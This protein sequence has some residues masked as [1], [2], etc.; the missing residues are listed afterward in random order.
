MAMNCIACDSANTMP[1]FCMDETPVFCNVLWPDRPHALAA[2]RGRIDLTWCGACGMIFNAAFDPHLADYSPEYE[3]SLHCSP[4]FQRYARQLAH[5]LIVRHNLR[6]KTILEVGCGRGEFLTLLCD[7]E[8]NRGLGYDPSQRDSQR[9]TR[10]GLPI[11]IYGRPLDQTHAP[12]SADLLCCRHVLEHLFSPRP[13]LGLLRKTL[14]N[15]PHAAAF[16]EVPNAGRTFF[17]DGVWDIL[18]EHCGYYTRSSLKALFSRSGYHVD[19]LAET[20]EGQFLTVHASL[21]GKSIP[22]PSD[23][24]E[25]QNTAAAI[26]TFAH[27]MNRQLADWR[28]QLVRLERSGKRTVVWGGG[29]KGI[30]FLTMLGISSHLIPYVVDLNP[31]KQG[32]FVP[33]TG[34]KIVSPTFLSDYQPQVILVMNKIYLGEIRWQIERMGLRAELR[35]A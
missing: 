31:L 12:G 6:Q 13:F 3:N 35:T 25:L 26:K 23:D 2:P 32:R 16:F 17:G 28:N 30:S 5:E 7:L 4:R 19:E 15:N 33:I 27:R 22:P 21:N 18:Y 11:R 20:Y 14:I 9:T 34:Q 8:P 10:H 24:G 1:F 29:S